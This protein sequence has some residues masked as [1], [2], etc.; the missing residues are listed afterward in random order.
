MT[1]KEKADYVRGQKQD[2]P[3][4]C[5]WPGCDKQVPP[6]K[7]GCSKHWFSLPKWLR[8]KIWGAYRPGQEKDMSPSREYVLVAREVQEWIKANAKGESHAREDGGRA[9]G[10]PAQPDG[11]L[12]PEA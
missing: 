1:N 10:G 6:A 5:H 7:W 12:F 8:D 2:R 3:H 9:E 4:H 11:T